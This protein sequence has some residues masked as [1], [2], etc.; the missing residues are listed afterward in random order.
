MRTFSHNL[1][2]GLISSV[3]IFSLL[4]SINCSNRIALSGDHLLKK[5]TVTLEMKNGEKLTGEIREVDE[6]QIILINEVGHSWG[7]DRSQIVKVYGPRPVF[8][9]N[10]RIISEREIKVNKTNHN[11]WLFTMSGG[12]LSAGVGFFLSNMISRANDELRNSIVPVGTGL[13]T[14]GGGYWFSRM[15]WKK[16]RHKAIQKI[17]Y[18]RELDEQ[19]LSEEELKKRNIEQ[20]LQQLK[21]NRQ[22][23]EQ[24]LEFLRQ[25]IQ[26]K[27]KK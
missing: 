18:L 13:A 3:T 20:E 6:Q 5:Q 21:K 22:Q 16:D 8:D 24:E 11:L 19:Y 7:A 23:Q 1:K 27:E 9:H 17:R 10:N 25:Q 2:G 14:V 12:L 15:G 4:F 26:E